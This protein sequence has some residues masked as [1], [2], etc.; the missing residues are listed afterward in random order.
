MHIQFVVLWY[1][2]VI[3]ISIGQ[4]TF[5][6]IQVFDLKIFHSQV[7]MKSILVVGVGIAVC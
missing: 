3:S 7:M 6:Q 4:A 5:C 1:I 2:E